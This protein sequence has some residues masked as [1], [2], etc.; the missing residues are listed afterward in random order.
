MTDEVTA[1]RA[2]FK[3]GFRTEGN[4]VNCYLM[5]TVAGAGPIFLLS[6]MPL[7]VCQTDQTIFDDWKEIMKRALAVSMKEALGIESIS[8]IEEEG[9]ENER[10]SG[11]G[12]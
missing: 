12:H 4:F 2:T 9:P 3:L 6:T 8:M 1:E 11:G 10:S 7:R 5:P